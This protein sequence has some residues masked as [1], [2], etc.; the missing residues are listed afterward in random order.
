MGSRSKQ[1]AKKTQAPLSLK[2][3]AFSGPI[4]PPEILELYHKIDPLLVTQIMQMSAQEQEMRHKH[5]SL[6]VY[7]KQKKH[8]N[9]GFLKNTNL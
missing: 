7:S 1:V 5:E 3:T 4:P 8:F 9:Y 6:L 2:Q